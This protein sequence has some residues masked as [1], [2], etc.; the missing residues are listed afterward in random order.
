MQITWAKRYTV[1][2]SNS[3]Q[4]K[5]WFWCL[6]LFHLPFKNFLWST[7]LNPVVI[8]LIYLDITGVVARRTS[9]FHFGKVLY[10]FSRVKQ[11]NSIDCIC[12]CILSYLVNCKMNGVM[13]NLTHFHLKLIILFKLFTIRAL[14][15]ETM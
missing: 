8:P 6:L 7:W 2:L 4:E 3:V 15:C 12:A 5:Y 14:W 13:I 1:T 10:S 11:K 9:D